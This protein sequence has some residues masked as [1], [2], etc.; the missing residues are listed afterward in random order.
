MK[1][2]TVIS[3]LFLLVASV[4]LSGCIFPYWGDEGGGHRGGGHYEDHHEGRHEGH[5]EGG[6]RR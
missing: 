4:M 2:S 6:D 1:K 5:H 3:S